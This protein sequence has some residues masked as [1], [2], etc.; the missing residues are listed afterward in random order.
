MPRYTP[1]ALYIGGRWI[2]AD[3][4]PTLSVVDP[5][6]GTE[7]GRLPVA[8]PEDVDAAL[9]L[10]ESAWP[11]WAGRPAHER[12][13]ILHRAAALVRE[14]LEP[15]ARILTL[16]QGKPLF[17]A[18]IEIALNA[19]LIDWMAE[20]CR[21][22]YGRVIPP[23]S[24]GHRWMAVQEPVGVV[25]A[26]SPWNFP[27][28]SPTRKMAG[29]LAAGCCCIL[30]AAEET[31]GTAVELVRAMHDAGLP[32]GV[33][34]LLFGEPAR[35]S[36]HLICSPIVRKITFTGSTAIGAQL[37]AMAAAHLKPA[38]MELG[39]HAPVVVFDDV[40]VPATA[41]LAVASA[42][43]NAGQVCVSPSR[44]YVHEGIYDAFAAA[45]A[46][47]AR[48][49][50]LGNGLEEATRMGPLIHERRLQAVA[51]LVADARDRGATVLC[52]GQR[53]EG[54]GFFWEPTVLTDLPGDA[55]VL[56]E[57]P[58]GPIAPLIRFANE[59]EVLAHANALPYGLAAYLF[60][61]DADRAARMAD[62][63]RCGLVGV[64]TFSISG[65]ETPWG[66]VGHSGYGREGGIEG[67][68]GYMTT[69]FISQ[70]IQAL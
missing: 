21:R 14:R 60:T 9:T 68:E 19:D 59:E 27:G 7:I 3:Q 61:R 4:R 35:I 48:Q 63:L 22:A 24:P 34:S 26:F 17:E 52:G 25:A 65:P 49:L 56:R 67:L 5:A 53:R 31:P 8:Q 6:T 37:G 18:R 45:F 33:L 32:P 54:P 11:A 12:A 46:E 40:D 38:T 50:R 23:R 29:P 20:E 69:K 30:K 15:I 47:G 10:A 66:G 57:E 70:Q 36:E 13:A 43:R 55:R 2:E 64:N 16:E 58:F 62:G 51:D 28:T 44:I 41:A 1:L 39:G 42:F